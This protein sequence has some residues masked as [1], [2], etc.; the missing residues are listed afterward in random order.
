MLPSYNFGDADKVSGY[1]ALFDTGLF[2]DA[3]GW[4]QISHWHMMVGSL[5]ALTYGFYA[6][7]LLIIL[8]N[9]KTKIFF[10]L[11]GII[12]YGSIFLFGYE[13]YAS[14]SFLSFFHKAGLGF[15]L[16]TIGALVVQ[17]AWGEGSD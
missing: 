1:S 13:W 6:I 16:G 11:S 2:F 15:Y 8:T 3:D 4:G 12:L 17:F 14:G 5:I 9:P 7:N 10:V